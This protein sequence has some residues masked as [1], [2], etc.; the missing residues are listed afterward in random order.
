M[1]TF[2]ESPGQLDDYA[3]ASRLSYALWTD[4]PDETLLRLAAEGKLRHTEILTEQIDRMLDD[5]RSKQFINSF[6]DQVVEA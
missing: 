2:V 4:M 3:I 6:T 1:L 5:P